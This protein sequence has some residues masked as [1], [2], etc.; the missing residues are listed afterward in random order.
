MKIFIQIIYLG[1]KK[2]LYL[3]LLKT[4]NMETQKISS[5]HKIKAIRELKGFSQ[6][7]VSSKLNL[8]QNAL[9]KIEKGEIKLSFDK[10]C[11]LSKVLETDI[12]TLLNF[13]PNNMFNNCQQFGVINTTFNSDS[14][15]VQQL[16]SSKDDLIK[17]KEERI[18]LL[19]KII[20]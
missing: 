14:N 4:T 5:G 13:E 6:E 12:N 1:C 8:S 17:E 18:K 2:Q 15:L 11:E 10:A 19:E 9:S 20:Q 7:Y 16:I 3:V